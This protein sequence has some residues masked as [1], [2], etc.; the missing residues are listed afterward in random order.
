M[1]DR[2]KPLPIQTQQLHT[3]SRMKEGGS[4]RC[5]NVKKLVGMFGGEQSR[6][7]SYFGKGVIGGGIVENS[8]TERGPLKHTGLKDNKRKAGCDRGSV[9]SKRG[10]W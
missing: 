4:G 10:R 5:R 2:L 8:G 9:G 1:E 6:I 3:E 7:T